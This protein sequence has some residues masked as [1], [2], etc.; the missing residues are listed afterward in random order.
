MQ[1]R[2]PIRALAGG[3]RPGRRVFSTIRVAV[4]SVSAIRAAPENPGR[5]YL[6]VQNKSSDVVYLAIGS[7]ATVDS[8]EIA[9]LDEFIVD[10]GAP[11]EEISLLG[12]RTASQ[13]VL[14]V[15]GFSSVR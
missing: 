1:D 7:T 14:V 13:K 15:E 8:I 12:S 5:H 9:A 10:T 2:F 4:D 3:N 11:T 6:F